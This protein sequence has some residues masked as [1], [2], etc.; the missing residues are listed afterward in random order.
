M[1]KVGRVS[2]LS[3]GPGDLDLLTVRAVRVLAG[4]QVL[5][6]DDLVDPAIATLAPSARVIDVGKRGG[7][8]S[9]SQQFICNLLRRCAIQGYD[10]V[11]VKGGEALLFGRAG[12]E[13]DYLRAHGIEVAI[14]NGITAGVAAAASLG[15]SLTHRDHCHGVTFV[16]AHTHSHGHPDWAALAKTGTTLVIYMGAARLESICSGLM[17]SLPAET[18]AAIV[19]SATCAGER[20][21]V[22]TLAALP[23]AARMAGFASPA[24]ILIGNALASANGGVSSN[25]SQPARLAAAR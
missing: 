13:I 1:R 19:Q 6:I 21:L 9:T 24:I 4:A 18:P 12:E 10:V 5:L 25:A 17:E 14:V 11:R 8:R 7:R 3:A 15:A 20:R 2:L 16:T 23:Q 22:S